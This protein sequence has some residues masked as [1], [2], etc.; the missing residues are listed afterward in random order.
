[1][2]T[3]L[4]LYPIQGKF[5]KSPVTYAIVLKFDTLVHYTGLV[6]KTEN[7][8]RDIGRRQVAVRRNCHFSSVIP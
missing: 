7:D 4:P 6:V 2:L 1:M 3:D 8:R 5:A